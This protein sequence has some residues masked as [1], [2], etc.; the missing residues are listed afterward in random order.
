MANAEDA[1][2]IRQPTVHLEEAVYGNIEA[3]LVVDQERA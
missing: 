1:L 2:A 3:L